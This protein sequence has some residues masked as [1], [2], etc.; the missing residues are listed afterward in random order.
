[1]IGDT[2]TVGSHDVREMLARN[3]MVQVLTRSE[4][5]DRQEN[6]LGHAARSF[7]DFAMETARIGEDVMSQGALT[8]IS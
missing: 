4:D 5:K 8:S 2:G 7:E 1:V 3:F 6:L